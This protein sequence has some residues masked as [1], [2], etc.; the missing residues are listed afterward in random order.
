MTYFLPHGAILVLHNCFR[1]FIQE[2]Q[3][4]IN[5]LIVL[6]YLICIKFVKAK[7]SLPLRV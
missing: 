3:L 6:H 4:I 2:N 5:L 7:K 1:D